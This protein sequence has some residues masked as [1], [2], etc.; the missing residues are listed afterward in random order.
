MVKQWGKADLGT[1]KWRWIKYHP[2]G[3]SHC[4]REWVRVDLVNYCPISKD[5]LLLERAIKSS[6]GQTVRK[7]LIGAQS[8]QRLRGM[9]ERGDL[10]FHDQSFALIQV[11]HEKGLPRELAQRIWGE[12]FLR[13]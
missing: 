2:L 13:S 12:L 6:D 1:V 8:I 10:I 4:K 11:V 3:S 7:E 5:F 9:K